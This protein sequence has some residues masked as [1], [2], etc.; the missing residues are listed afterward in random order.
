MAVRPAD[1]RLVLAARGLRLVRS[2][3]PPLTQKRRPKAAPV[4]YHNPRA[5]WG[6]AAGL[7]AGL[8]T[9]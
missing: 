7:R 2:D 6:I 3:P 5:C 8:D 4:P 9:G 1:R